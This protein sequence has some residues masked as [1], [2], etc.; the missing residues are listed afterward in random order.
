MKIKFIKDRTENAV[1]GRSFKKDE[2]YEVNE[3]SGQHWI[4]R[5]VAVEVPE[6]TRATKEYEAP[7]EEKAAQL[8]AN[9]ATHETK[10]SHP[11]AATHE[12][13]KRPAK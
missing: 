3:S 5:G 11:H 6:S 12:D 9:A 13:A 2:V 10:E 7:S 1:N 4:N 8:K